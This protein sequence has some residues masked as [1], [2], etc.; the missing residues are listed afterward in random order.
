MHTLIIG[1]TESGKTTLGKILCSSYKAAG[2][3]TIVF[4]AAFNEWRADFQTGDADKFFRYA[5]RAR[6]CMLFVDEAGKAVKWSARERVDL[7]TLFR[8]LGHSALFLGQRPAMIAP[9]VRYNCA[10]LCLFRTSREDAADLA[11]E[12][13]HREIMSAPDL[14]AGSFLDITRFSAPVL[15][16][17]F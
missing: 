6:R 13:G 3:G 12:W 17:V 8:H 14:P 7:A 10:R 11:A 2:F 15:R 9:S 1:M 4:D 5:V 16:K